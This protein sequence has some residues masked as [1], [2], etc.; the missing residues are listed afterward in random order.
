MLTILGYTGL[1]FLLSALLCFA[2][3]Q[4]LSKNSR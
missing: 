3:G 4:L 2:L 1:W